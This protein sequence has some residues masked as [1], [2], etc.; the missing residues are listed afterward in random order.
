MAQP[1][2]WT[3]VA[4][5]ETAKEL[6]LADLTLAACADDSSIRV[7]RGLLLSLS[8]KFAA[9]ALATTGKEL[10]LPGRT[11]AEVELLVGWMYHRLCVEDFTLDIVK[12]L[13]SMAT[14]YEIPALIKDV[15][16]WLCREVKA[17]RILQPF[18]PV[19]ITMTQHDYVRLW[20]SVNG[21]QANTILASCP[22]GHSAS[23]SFFTIG[24]DGTY[25][26]RGCY[27]GGKQHNFSDSLSAMQKAALEAAFVSEANVSNKPTAETFSDLLLLARTYKLTGLTRLLCDMLEKLAPS[28]AQLVLVAYV[29][30]EMKAS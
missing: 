15:D 19:T 24:G 16:G 23:N 3:F 5:G 20:P 18:L 28:Y 8:N 29:I 4:E 27:P 21:T 22:N 7:H 14:E 30:G 13:V 11:G 2:T 25:T 10:P 1:S 9:I 26:C 6:P 12:Q 17:E